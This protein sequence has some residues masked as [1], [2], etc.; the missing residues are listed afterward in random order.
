MN[1]RKNIALFLALTVL[2]SLIVGG[3]IMAEAMGTA[4]DPIVSLSYLNTVVIPQITQSVK[5]S[6]NQIAAQTA[7]ETVQSMGLSGGGGG[8]AFVSVQVF[9][10]QVIEGKEGTEVILRSGSARAVCPG[11]VGLVDAT[12]GIDLLGDKAVE[13]NHVYIIPRADGRGIRMASD[14]YIMIK[15]AYEIKQ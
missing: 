2:C 3:Y 8:G 1:K 4:E 10:G 5:D 14:G 12:G 11:D 9:N 7:R 15:G 13:S 6:V